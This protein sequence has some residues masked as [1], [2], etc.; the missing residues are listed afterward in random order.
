MRVYASNNVAYTAPASG[1]RGPA[2][3]FSVAAPDV[4][5]AP[6]AAAPPRPLTSLDALIALQGFD[7]PSERRRRAIKRG[8]TALD[9][10][11]ALKIGLL[12]GTLDGAALARLKAAAPELIEASGDPRLDLILGEIELRA[13]VELAK[14]GDNGGARRP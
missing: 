12:A 9:A 4:P 2:G 1:R 8:R 6:A 7:D 3:S 11:D 10:L 5:R 13:A 14:F